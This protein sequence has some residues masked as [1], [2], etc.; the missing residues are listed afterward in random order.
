MEDPTQ[1]PESEKRTLRASDRRGT[2]EF[3]ERMRK[4]AAKLRDSNDAIAAPAST[5]QPPKKELDRMKATK[6]NEQ[7]A[8]AAEEDHLCEIMTEGAEKL[9]LL[10]H[11]K[12]F[13]NSEPETTAEG[14]GEEQMERLR[15]T[16]AAESRYDL[17]NRRESYQ[18]SQTFGTNMNHFLKEQ[19]V[20]DQVQQRA[21]TFGETI[22]E[23]K[24]KRTTAR[25]AKRIERMVERKG[26]R[27][28]AS[29]RAELRSRKEQRASKNYSSAEVDDYEEDEL[30]QKKRAYGERDNPE[31]GKE[32]CEEEEDPLLRPSSMEKRKERSERERDELLLRHQ[33]SEALLRKK[34]PPPLQFNNKGNPSSPPALRAAVREAQAEKAKV[35]MTLKGRNLM[36]HN[37]NLPGT[38][39][40]RGSRQSSPG[41][42]LRRGDVCSVFASPRRVSQAKEIKI[43][44][45][46]LETECVYF[47][48]LQTIIRAF[49]V[50][51]YEAQR[52]KLSG[53]TPKGKWDD[54]ALS[55]DMVHNIFGGIATLIPIHSRLLD[56]LEEVL[57]ELEASLSVDSFSTFYPSSRCLSGSASDLTSS[58]CSSIPSFSSSSQS[59][60]GMISTSLSSSPLSYSAFSLASPFRSSAPTPS[61]RT[62]SSEVLSFTSASS[63]HSHS[64]SSSSSTS[65]TS[66]TVGCHT[67]GSNRN[68][69]LSSP[70][71]NGSWRKVATATSCSG[72]SSSS[73]SLS[74]SE[75]KSQTT[76][77]GRAKQS[78]GTC[79]A[80]TAQNEERGQEDREE[81]VGRSTTTSTAPPPRVDS[82]PSFPLSPEFLL[83]LEKRREKR[84]EEGGRTPPST[85]RHAISTS[86][87]NIHITARAR[88]EALVKIGQLFHGASTIMRQVY[89]EYNFTFSLACF[90]HC[91]GAFPSFAYFYSQRLLDKEAAVEYTD[92]SAY[93]I[94]PVQRLPRY[95]LFFKELMRV[96]ESSRPEWEC[97]LEDVPLSQRT[98]QIISDAHDALSET[99]DFVDVT[100]QQQKD[101]LNA[102]GQIQG[103]KGLVCRSR[104]LLLDLQAFKTHNR[105]KNSRVRLFLF[106]DL[107]VIATKTGKD[108]QFSKKKKEMMAVDKESGSS[109]FRGTSISMVKIAYLL[110][111][112]GSDGRSQRPYCMEAAVLLDELE[113]EL[114]KD[115][116]DVVKGQVPMT[117]RRKERH[118][119]SNDGREPQV[120]ITSWK[121]YVGK[122]EVE[123]WYR[124]WKEA[125][126]GKGGGT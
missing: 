105:K 32:E 77:D 95:V 38:G 92:F 75:N 22:N 63:T 76:Q 54:E 44:K 15:R 40:L 78:A 25:K 28:S 87:S 23:A 57:D 53:E 13:K 115:T 101:G 21:E 103:S 39:S 61:A 18:R 30:L 112:K 124:A 19:A 41:S 66:H 109:K 16:V 80:S 72:A 82:L 122:E 100:I 73:P 48:H 12:E 83:T 3:Y 46:I 37:H 71:H 55:L 90:R 9:L 94:M 67:S 51:L 50:P 34:H 11:D 42:T 33:L 96:A 126:T 65:A 6:P 45:E 81:G 123:S 117:I 14:G 121:V 120:G 47:R 125:T 24:A 58:S 114:S 2:Y 89:G 119:A 20:N 116:K 60:P 70:H 59:L 106:N 85:R 84:L 49:V 43:M 8:T 27:N 36:A 86:E 110:S 108:S 111:D 104:K 91:M 1:E 107:L 99:A 118:G 4:G 7:Q 102:L 56:A 74:S 113:V 31:E 5:T 17:A 98:F 26:K 69:S 93:L 10:V 88:M 97:D 62:S 64:N 68:R 79:R 35:I 29:L 52:R